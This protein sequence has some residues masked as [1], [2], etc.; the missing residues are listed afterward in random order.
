MNIVSNLV[1][2]E[3]STLLIVDADR[4]ILHFLISRFAHSYNVIA[5]SNGTEALQIAKE[6]RLS[7]II[8]DMALPGFDGFRIC[9]AMRNDLQ[10]CHIPLIFMTSN[11]TTEQ[12]IQ[13]YETG[14]DD[15]IDKPINFELLNAKVTRLVNSRLLLN[16]KY[17]LNNR[18]IEMGPKIRIKEDRF[19]E[20]LKHVLEADLFDPGFSIEVLSKK[21][22]TS[23]TQLYR[24]VK[25]FTGYPPVDFIR[26]LRL[27]NAYSLLTH[28]A[29]TVTEACYQSGFNNVSYFIKCFKKLYGHTPA[30]FGK[31]KLDIK[32]KNHYSVFYDRNVKVIETCLG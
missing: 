30:D 25:E 26:K 16:D 23:S 12:I 20:R 31:R 7:L 32:I 4:Q 8:A 5:V 2:E 11:S 14:V 18:L 1:N 19:L 22:G 21:M 29:I 9:Q 13:G 15:F 24:N 6:E 27:Q 28:Q 17:L 10:L 3:R